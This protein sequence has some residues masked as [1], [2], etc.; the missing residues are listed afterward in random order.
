[1]V[2]FQCQC[3][4]SDQNWLLS[5]DIVPSNAPIFGLC[6]NQVKVPL[7]SGEDGKEMKWTS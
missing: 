6:Q 2:A 3:R 1:M 5:G 4:S 7:L